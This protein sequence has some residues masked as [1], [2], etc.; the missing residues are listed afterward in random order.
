MS[1]T[2][3]ASVTARIRETLNTAPSENAPVVAPTRGVTYIFDTMGYDYTPENGR[4]GAAEFLA[5]ALFVWVG[6]GTVVS[7]QALLGL[8]PDTTNDNT[9]L[10]AVAMSFGFAIVVLAYTIAPI[11]GGHINPAVTFAFVLLGDMS[12][13]KGALYVVSQCLGALLGA[14]LLWGCTASQKLMELTAGDNGSEAPPFLLGINQ[15]N[16][17]LPVGSAFLIECCGTFLLVWTVLM[18]AVYKKSIAANLAPMAIGWSVMLAHFVLVPF[19]GCG[20]NPARSFGPMLVVIMAGEKVGFDVSCRRVECTVHRQQQNGL[21]SAVLTTYPFCF[22]S[23]LV[24]VLRRSLCWL[25]RG[26]L[27]LQIYFQYF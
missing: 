19:T 16:P 4:Q 14:A 5:T 9:F 21:S 24:G 18:T 8:D 27:D 13:R 3:K 22:I 15:V 10:T 11:S 26:D 12:P 25:C 6:C 17:N 20:I 2:P 7:S 1:T 23:G